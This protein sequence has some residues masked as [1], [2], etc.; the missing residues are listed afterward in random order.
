MPT[1]SDR[2]PVIIMIGL[3]KDN[4]CQAASSYS[5]DKVEHSGPAVNFRPSA[6]GYAAGWFWAVIDDFYFIV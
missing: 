3:P 1:F 4:M 6:R 5:P 2:G